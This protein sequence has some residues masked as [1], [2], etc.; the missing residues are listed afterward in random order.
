MGVF[1]DFAEHIEGAQDRQ[2]GVDESEELLVEDEEGLKLDLALG[3]NS[4]AAP[5]ADGEDVVA[6]MNETVA[7]FLGGGRRLH[8]LLH[9]PTLIGQLDDELCHCLRSP[10]F[11][12]SFFLEFKGTSFCYRYS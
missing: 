9:P 7:Q 6:G 11:P 10:A 8:L 4:Q 5:G 12:E 1:L 3:Q 2:P